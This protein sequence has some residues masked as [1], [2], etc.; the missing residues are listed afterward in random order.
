MQST[1]SFFLFFEALR[2]AEKG[3]WLIMF[4]FRDLLSPYVRQSLSKPQ[5]N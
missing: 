3:S 2:G 4:Y 1:K 5:K